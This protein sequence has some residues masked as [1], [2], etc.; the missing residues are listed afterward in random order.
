MN[1]ESIVAEVISN[2]VKDALK[3]LFSKGMVKINQ[4]ATEEEISEAIREMIL[5]GRYRDDIDDLVNKSKVLKNPKNSPTP[6]LEGISI[7]AKRHAKKASKKAAKK[8]GKKPAKKV[9]RKKAAKKR[10]G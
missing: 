10:A 3:E 2:L 5:T 8:A 6:Y 7:N 9:A 1:L 4:K